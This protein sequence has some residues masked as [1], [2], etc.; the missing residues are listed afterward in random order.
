LKVPKVKVSAFSATFLRLTTLADFTKVAFSVVVAMGY[1]G[2]V[3][4]YDG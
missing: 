2:E 3:G 1:H 4:G